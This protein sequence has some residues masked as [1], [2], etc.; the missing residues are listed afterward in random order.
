M[1]KLRVRVDLIHNYRE[2]HH[3]PTYPSFQ[4]IFIQDFPDSLQRWRKEG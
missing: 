1:R 4:V 3:L 2:S